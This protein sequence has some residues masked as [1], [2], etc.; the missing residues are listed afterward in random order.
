MATTTMAA[1]TEREPQGPSL[2]RRLLGDV[3]GR[4]VASYVALLL[5]ASLATVLIV[6]SV[7]LVRLDDEVDSAL[8][9]EVDEFRQLAGG[10]DPETGEPFAGQVK[11]IFTVFLSRNIPNEGERLIG[12]PVD[13]VPQARPQGSITPDLEARFEEWRGIRSTEDGEFETA[14]GGSVRY[15]AIPVLKQGEPAGTFV[16]ANFL[17][18][19]R[20]EVEEAVTIVALVSGI[21]LLGGS[22]LAFLAVGRVV[23]PLRDL[24]DAARSVTGSDMTK[25]IEVRGNDEL[26]ELSRTFNT[27]LDRLDL[28]FATQRAFIRDAGHEMRTPIAIVRGH[29]ELLAEDAGD[30]PERAETLTMLDGELDRMTRFVNDMLLL[31]KSERPDFLQ[32][33]TVDLGALCDEALLAARALGER[34]WEIDERADGKIVGDGH[35]LTQALVNL[36]GNSVANSLPGDRISIGSRI[37]GREAVLWVEDEGRGIDPAEHE[38]IFEPFRRGRGARYEGSGLG[39]PIVAAIAG[40]HGGTVEIESELDRGTRVTLRLPVEGPGTS[41]DEEARR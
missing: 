16:V 29:L 27:M 13:G 23:A 6:R 32:L 10:I 31:A 11:R 36:A 3:R 1:M 30:D 8:V 39:L 33:E 24:R 20:E 41:T 34:D 4:V 21:I 22:A 28:A 2:I 19:E 14:S 17:E 40:A 26:A 7:L 5:I 15:V 18:G 9:Q 25:R 37:A 38:A 12:L 35:R